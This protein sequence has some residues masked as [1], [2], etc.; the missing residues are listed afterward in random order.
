MLNILSLKQI[1]IDWPIK[2]DKNLNLNQVFKCCKT[3]WSDIGL[4]LDIK[5]YYIIANQ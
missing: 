4:S 3:P 2:S 5:L 1:D